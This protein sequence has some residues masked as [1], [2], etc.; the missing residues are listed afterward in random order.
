MEDYNI[1]FYA[2]QLLYGLAELGILVGSILLVMKHRNVATLLMLFG[3]I[4]SIVFY[5]LNQVIYLFDV[6][7]NMD[8]LMLFQGGFSIAGGFCFLIFAIG[9]IMLPLQTNFTRKE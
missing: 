2:G 5:I 1:L 6:L 4:F 8:S 7:N 3:S 9:L